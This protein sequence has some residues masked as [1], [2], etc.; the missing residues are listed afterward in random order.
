MFAIRWAGV[1]SQGI[2]AIELGLRNPM[3]PDEAAL[4]R[5]SRSKSA[6]EDRCDRNLPTA[7]ASMPVS[8]S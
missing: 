8:I 5:I 4:R 3:L 2:T 6:G 1:Y 7:S